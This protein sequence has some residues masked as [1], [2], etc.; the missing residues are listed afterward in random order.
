MML[1]TLL[2]IVETS[3]ATLPLSG[4]VGKSKHKCKRKVIAGWTD[5]VEPFRKTCNEAYL[6]WQD[7]GRPSSGEIFDAKKV[8]YN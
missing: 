4:K 6:A 1:D 2:S 5:E 7:A 3:Y 8:S